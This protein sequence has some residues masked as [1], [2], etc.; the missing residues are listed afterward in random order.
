M[1]LD[2]K[3]VNLVQLQYELAAAGIPV[4][5]LGATGNDLHTYTAVGEPLDLPDTA[6]P[7]VAA[8]VAMRDKSDVEYATEFQSAGTT[9][10]RQ[11]QIRDILAGLLPRD[12]VPM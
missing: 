2:G 8:H 1:N 12:K 3:V 9:A 7:V 5:A 11:Q 4:V 10:T 6:A